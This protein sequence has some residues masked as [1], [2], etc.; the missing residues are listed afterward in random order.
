MMS[1]VPDDCRGDGK[2]F[3]SPK[4]TTSMFSAGSFRAL[5]ADE[6]ASNDD[7]AGQDLKA[8][9]DACTYVKTVVSNFQNRIDTLDPQAQAAVNQLTVDLRNILLVDENK[10]LLGED[11]KPSTGARP[12]KKDC[13]HDHGDSGSSTASSDGGHARR[14]IRRRKPVADTA[15]PVSLE[16]LAGILSR[17][18]NRTMIKPEKYEMSSGQ[19]LKDFLRVFE[20]YCTNAFKESSD[21]WP[22]ELGRFLSG[23]IHDAYKVL[24]IPG[25]SYESLKKKLIKWCNDSRYVLKED[26][27]K[28]FERAKC[29][30]GEPIRIYAAR[31]ERAFMMAHPNKSIDTNQTLMRKFMESIPKAFKDRLSAAS[32]VLVMEN[33]DVTWDGILSLA[34]RY[35]AERDRTDAVINDEDA[36][37]WVSTTPN[38]SFSTPRVFE[39]TDKQPSVERVYR[40]QSISPNST[41]R[42]S[43]TFESR[44]CFHCHRQGHVRS[45][46]RRLHGLC[47]VC[48][49]ADHRISGCP[50]RRSSDTAASVVPSSLQQRQQS[51]VT[52]TEEPA[53]IP[54]SG[55]NPL[56]YRSPAGQGTPCR[57]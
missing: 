10:P 2:A 53:V 29:G 46:C 16:Q 55:N 43:S 19:P 39:P 13:V 8:L 3:P 5:G 26:T 11:V 20:R 28:Q 12:K 18:D 23:P 50:L 42:R 52:F 24:K 27:L 49:S 41:A 57:S 32:S 34:S 15:A 51:R 44:K 33:R 40:Q 9:Q 30:S 36:T 17:F 14:S 37:V 6:M 31:L 21:M 45:K 25:E 56:N 54:D 35:D 1:D 22:T 38:R 48:G 7:E 47:L 4:K